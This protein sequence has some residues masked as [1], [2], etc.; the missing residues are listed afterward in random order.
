MVSREM[1]FLHALVPFSVAEKPLE[2]F[3]FSAR[4]QV[5]ER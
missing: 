1:V 5:G 3:T 2:L 4:E